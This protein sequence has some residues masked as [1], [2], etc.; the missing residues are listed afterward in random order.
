MTTIG[1][2]G[3]GNM[4]A[5]VARV[6][7]NNHHTP[8]LLSNR[9]VK[10]AEQLAEELQAIVCT[11]QQIFEQADV[12]FLGVKPQQ[13]EALLA[14]YQSIL[15][16]VPSKLII[17]MAAGLTLQQL[18]SMLPS[19]HRLIRMMPNTPLAVGEGVVTYVGAINI[20]PEDSVLF[21]QLLGN[22]AFVVKVD[23]AQLDAATAV[24][25][26]GPA[27]VYLFIEA[28]A[29]AGVKQGLS[30]ELSVQLAAKTVQGAGEMVYQLEKHPAMLKDEVCSPGGSTI[31]GVAS[32]EKTGLRSSV[33]EAV[34]A[35][36][37]RT[38]ELG[39]QEQRIND[40]EKK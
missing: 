39:K 7:A 23:E 27:F 36:H 25:G 34:I 22:S 20:E 18:A 26:C 21:E 16:I 32:L 12:I 37:E 28:M 35:A 10:K 33:I 19:Q 4:G 3:V 2:I 6:V 40:Y 9:T 13:V 24:A 38:Q 15:Q 14:E 8:L 1:F 11:S 30:R 5:I 17:S 29:D 31:A